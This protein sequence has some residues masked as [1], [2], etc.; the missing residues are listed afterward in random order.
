MAWTSVTETTIQKCFA[1]CG[2]KTSEAAVENVDEPADD[3]APPPPPTC[4]TTPR[5]QTW[6]EFVTMDYGIVATSIVEDNWE[7]PCTYR[8]LYLSTQCMKTK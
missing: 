1:K 3:P 4:T 7:D 8:S 2:F 5:R 6:D